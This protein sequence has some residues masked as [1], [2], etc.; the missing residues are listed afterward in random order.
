MITEA[1]KVEI[2]QI[3]FAEA[4]R[5]AE[6]MLAIDNVGWDKLTAFD[7]TSGGVPLATLN[8]YADD[9]ADM[10]LTSPPFIRAIQLRHAYIF[11]RGFHIKGVSKP[12]HREVIR[13]P[14]NREAIFSPSAFYAVESAMLTHGNY[15]LMKVGTR[16]KT[17]YI[18]VPQDQIHGVITDEMDTSRIYFVL[19]RWSANGNDYAKWIPLNRHKTDLG[20]SLPKEMPAAP[21]SD[22][23]IPVA[24]D[25]S[26]FIA[27]N[28]RQ[29][30]HTWGVPLGL[31]IKIWVAMYTGYLRD[32]ATLTKALTNIAWKISTNSTKAAERVATSVIQAKAGSA[33]V[34][35]NGQDVQAMP[36]GNDVNFNNGQPL[37]A[38]IAT[39]VG[40]PVIALISSTGASGGAY[41]AATTLD[42]PTQKGMYAIQ[43]ARAE[44]LNEILEDLAGADAE[45]QFPTMASDATYRHAQS[46][47]N[48]HATGAIFQDEYREAALDLLNVESKHKG[49]P[50]PNG[51]NT[52]SDPKPE[53]DSNDS[54]P[55]DP[56]ARQ[57]NSG[58]VKGGVDQGDTN[59]DNDAD[60]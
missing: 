21:N 16:K 15:F 17:R 4:S 22:D 3:A 6:R 20:N 41:G 7:N 51:F 56:I 14:Y 29:T 27:H 31:A 46:L 50:K 24:Q 45:V 44:F 57:G 40:V 38:M 43:Q 49:L 12:E 52:W 54:Q 60:R 55:S 1:T 2:E 36:R 59:H 26:M 32:N 48:A 18:P 5:T 28:T 47:A 53:T 25:A 42:E 30:G 34:T 33:A 37:A 8:E 10:A 58:A 11:G 35:G 19:R 23:M 39:A 13:S 9:L